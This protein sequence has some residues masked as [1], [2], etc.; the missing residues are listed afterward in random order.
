MSTCAS[1]SNTTTHSGVNNVDSRLCVKAPCPSVTSFSLRLSVA[2]PLP[3]KIHNFYLM[4]QSGQAFWRT[5]KLMCLIS[6]LLRTPITLWILFEDAQTLPFYLPSF[7]SVLLFL[8]FSSQFPPLWTLFLRQLS[9]NILIYASTGYFFS[10]FWLHSFLSLS[11][12]KPIRSMQCVE[13]HLIKAHILF[14]VAV[15]FY[16]V[17]PFRV[18]IMLQNLQKI[19]LNQIVRPFK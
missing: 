12:C 1:L 7:V 18:L 15:R 19:E 8:S 10:L 5:M 6:G 16:R 2:L 17:R 14:W 9:D 3:D 11:R 4:V 13:F